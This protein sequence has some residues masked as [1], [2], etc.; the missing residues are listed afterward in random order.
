MNILLIHQYFLP[1]DGSGS[2]RWNDMAG[3]WA[4]D[5]HQVTV[6]AGM[7][8]YARGRKYDYCRGRY[9]IEERPNPNIRVIRTHVSE[10]YN[11]N[12]AG[13]LWAYVT[14]F[15]SSLWAGLF[16]A[17]RTFDLVIVTSPPLLLG[18][19]GWLLA[20]WLRKPLVV[21]IRDLWPDAPVQMGVLTSRVLVWLAYWLEA[22]LYRQADHIVVLTPGFR[23]YLI[24][25]KRVASTKITVIPNA[26]DFDLADRLTAGF[27]RDAF[28]KQHDMADHFWVIYAGAHGVANQ[29][30]TVLQAAAQLSGTNIRFLFM[31]DGTDKPR[32]QTQATA[33]N[34]PNV[35]FIDSVSKAM[36]LQF[37]LA[38]QAGIIS[39]QPLPVFRLMFAG[40]M[41]D[42][43]S[44]RVPV[45]MMID[46]ISRQVIETAQAGLFVEPE[47][48]DDLARQIRWYADHPEQARQH[49]QQGYDYAKTHYDRVVLA[50]KYLNLIRDVSASWQAKH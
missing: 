49:G 8:D 11:R 46:G 25:R 21:E 16:R 29:L 27:D 41:F 6:L 43:F 19:T 2:T 44:C 39:M 5:D 34:L 15:V 32:L 17:G 18:L 13:R 37:I 10:L 31:G 20:R 48:P 38:S 40:K 26:A 1:P 3:Q 28:R 23:E 50:E 35:R 22:F 33:L 30:T 12:W 45:L 4:T 47:N 7:L 36:A 24:D 14:Y 42:Y 9:V